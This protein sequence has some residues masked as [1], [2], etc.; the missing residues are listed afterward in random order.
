ME[1]NSNFETLDIGLAAF[2][3]VNEIELVEI[4]PL[5]N[6]QSKFVFRRPPQDLLDRWLSGEA[7]AS[8]KQTI[9]TYR[10][11]IRE[12]KTRQQAMLGGGRQ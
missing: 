11:L 4:I 6:Y 12:S 5:T 9:N 8:V 7:V 3:R 10:H 1:N 2:L